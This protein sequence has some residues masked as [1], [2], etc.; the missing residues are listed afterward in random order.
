MGGV[1]KMSEISLEPKGRERIEQRIQEIRARAGLDNLDRSEAFDS[2]LNKKMASVGG[3]LPPY[4]PFGGQ[5][6][7]PIGSAQL[8]RMANDAATAN[9]VDPILFDSLVEAESGFN[10]MSRSDAGAMGLTQLMPETARSLGV[11]DP[12]NPQENLNGGARYLRQLI[13]RY[14]GDK[15]LAVAAYNAGPGRVDRIKDVPNIPET[16]KYVAKIFRKVESKQ[17]V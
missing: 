15:R 9:G 12:F 11:R 2:H 6:S 4:D 17:G 5:L 14:G 8:R 3:T 7:G 10:P 16:Q 1:A 13:D